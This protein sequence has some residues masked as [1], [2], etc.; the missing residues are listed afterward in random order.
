MT[1]KIMAT[2][3]V[4]GAMFMFSGCGS[5]TPDTPSVPTGTAYY[6]DS[7][8]SGVN[9]TCGSTEGIT[10]DDGSFTFELGGSCTFYLGEIELRSV[11]AELLEDGNNVYETDV[12]IARILQSLD[13]D[14]DP[15]NGITLDADIIEALA[16]AGIAALPE[17]AEEMDAMIEVI[18]DNGGAVVSEEDAQAHLDETEAEAIAAGDIPAPVEPTLSELIVGKTLYMHWTDGTESWT[19]ALTFETNGNISEIED[20]QTRLTPYRVEGNIIYTTE[21]DNGV[22]VEMAHPVVEITS[23]Y[24]KINDDN[25]DAD[26]NPAYTFF[27]FTQADAAASTPMV[28][29][30]SDDGSFEVPTEFTQEVVSG[31]VWYVVE[32]G[33]DGNGAN[34]A[35]CNG[36]FDYNGVDTLT[37]AWSD[38]GVDGSATAPYSI[39]DGK[40][41]TSHDGKTETEILLSYDNDGITVRKDVTYNNGDTPPPSGNKKWFTTQPSADDFLSM[42]TN[43]E[44][45][46]CFPIIN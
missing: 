14:G 27:Y 15:S 7:V 19:N 40:V 9:Y 46:S 11:D 44:A 42:Y 39:V 34:V 2:S 16:E 36:V 8:V 1:K 33:T 6:I 38:N 31:S 22:M 24:I 5:D 12:K 28:D 21:E 18:V 3:V 29:N 25:F 20:G 17:T 37:V 26:D 4:M 35:Y 43:P 45:S 41:I 13:S 32:Y 10:G 30:Y 23:T